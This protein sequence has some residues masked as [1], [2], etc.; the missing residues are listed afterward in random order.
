MRIKKLRVLELCVHGHSGDNLGRTRGL[1]YDLLALEPLFLTIRAGY[2][3]TP[4]CLKKLDRAIVSL[5]QPLRLEEKGQ[6]RE[7][8][9]LVRSSLFMLLIFVGVVVMAEIVLYPPPHLRKDDMAIYIT[10]KCN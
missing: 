9:F 2:V 7:F 8:L 5:I 3:N 10:K 6:W 4:G 1:N